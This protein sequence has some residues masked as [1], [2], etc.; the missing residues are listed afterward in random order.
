MDT[1]K[2]EQKKI[3]LKKLKASKLE[4][5]NSNDA[6]T[7]VSEVEID[8]TVSRVINNE[9]ENKKE[10]AIVYDLK[11]NTKEDNSF[12][13]NCI[14]LAIFESDSDVNGEFL[15]SY[16]ARVN[17]P[18]IGFPY[19]RAYVTSVTTSAGLKPFILPTF[20]F[21]ELGNKTTDPDQENQEN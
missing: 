13:F 21:K 8:M 10:F 15:D 20:N 9:N 3:T 16:F 4:F 12:K 17:A 18:A 19:L 5:E 11:L 1:K 14:Y 6:G 7:G 2:Y